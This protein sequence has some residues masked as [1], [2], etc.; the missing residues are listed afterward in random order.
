MIRL[1]GL[2]PKYIWEFGAKNGVDSKA[3]VCVVLKQDPF[4]KPVVMLI[5]SSLKYSWVISNV[6]AHN[7]EEIKCWM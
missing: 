2:S 1:L 6:H 7:L 4:Y 3:Y 5:P